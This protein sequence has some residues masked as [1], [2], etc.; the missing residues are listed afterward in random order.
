MTFARLAEQFEELYAEGARIDGEKLQGRW[1]L[2]G[3]TDDQRRRF[4]RLAAAGARMTGFVG[5]DDD[6][7]GY[8]MN[9]VKSE[10]DVKRRT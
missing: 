10:Q 3:G 7:M 2:R 9:R 1:I 5:N 8:W 4:K 6:A